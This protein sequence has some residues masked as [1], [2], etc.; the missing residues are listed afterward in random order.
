MGGRDGRMKGRKGERERKTGGRMGREEER[1][2]AA[3]EKNEQS[4]RTVPSDLREKNVNEQQRNERH[5]I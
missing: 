4:S 1:K 3:Q 2:K 5:R